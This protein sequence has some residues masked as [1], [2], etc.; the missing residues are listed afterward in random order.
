M[1]EKI[2][3]RWQSELLDWIEAKSQPKIQERFSEQQRNDILSCLPVGA[4]ANYAINSMELMANLYRLWL[5]KEQM[6][7]TRDKI[8]RLCLKLNAELYIPNLLTIF[9]G[10][11]EVFKLRKILTTLIGQKATLPTNLNARQEAR[12]LYMEGVLQTWRNLGGKLG[13]AKSPM[14]KFFRAAWP[15]TLRKYRPND[16]AVVSWAYAFER[17]PTRFAEAFLWE[18]QIKKR[19][20][21]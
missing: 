17:Q 2:I 18:D 6:T 16:A 5:E 11:E 1:M 8:L 4:D 10:D 7:K 21:S 19:D 15:E 14:V 3:E 9:N 12:N 13:G 20:S